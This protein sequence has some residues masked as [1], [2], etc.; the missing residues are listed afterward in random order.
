MNPRKPHP[1]P[2]HTLE[3]S[4]R[5]VG[6]RSYLARSPLAASRSIPTRALLPGRSVGLDQRD[7]LDTS[8][9]YPYQVEGARFLRA[10]PRALLADEMG[11]GK[12]VQ[13]LR[14]LHRRARALVICPMSVCIAWNQQRA[15]W[16]PDLTFSMGE[17]RRPDEGELLVCS[18]DSLP[19]RISGS[20]VG[21]TLGLDEIHMVKSDGAKRTQRVRMLSR[22]A[23]RVH[24]LDGTPM[25]GAPLD[26]YGVLESL[27]LEHIYESRDRFIADCGGRKVRGRGPDDAYEWGDVHPRIR[28]ALQTVMLR[29]TRR[30]VLPH[31]PERQ[32]LD[33]PVEAPPEL[34]TYSDAARARRELA[35][36][37]IPA[38][39]DWAQTYAAQTPLLVFSAHR[40]P[41][42]AFENLEGAGA[43][44][45]TTALAE[46]ARLCDAFQRGDIR[47]LA[48]T[49]DAG[50]AGLTL[51]AAGAELFIDRHVTPA[52]NEQAEARPLRPGQRHQSVLIA[53][54]MCSHPLDVRREDILAE[55]ARLILAIVGD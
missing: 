42:L 32:F 35:I 27:G 6:K 49:L 41:V 1:A 40:E 26:L 53:R 3:K 24:G 48:I 52:M 16:R 38:A 28:E 44:T 39:I 21:V 51:T 13:F 8:G 12:T 54:M 37:R 11:V 10:R 50:G 30:E 18:Y 34:W 36:S 14:A 22:L 2:G 25:L 17:V 15:R 31:L 47:I 4:K 23:S 5:A 19:N 46:R 20:L 33:V 45:G 7:R 9:L 43:F 55:K 29:R